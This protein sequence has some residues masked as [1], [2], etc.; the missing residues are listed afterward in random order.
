[1]KTGEVIGLVGVIVAAIAAGAAIAVILPTR[2][3]SRPA[4]VAEERDRFKSR[5]R[6]LRDSQ[7]MLGDEVLE[8]SPREWRAFDTIPVLAKASWILDGPQDVGTIDINLRPD[9]D[10]PSISRLRD[11]SRVLRGMSLAG[12][13]TYSEAIRDVNP[14]TQ[15]FN[16]IIYRPVG[17]DTDGSAPLSMT[18]GVAGYFDY[19]DTSEV[20]AYEA[21]LHP[22]NL[23][24]RRRITDPFDLTNRVASLGV[25]TLTIQRSLSGATFIMHKRSGNF[26]V[27][28]ALYHVVPAG[29]FTPSDVGQA[30][31]RVDFELWRNIVREYAEEL[32]DIPDAQGTGGRRLDYEHASP[33]QEMVQA[34]R[35]DRFRLYTFGLALDPLTF[36]PELLTVAVIDKTVFDKIFPPSLPTT[37]EGVVIEDIP[38]TEE[39]VRAYIDAPTTRHGAKACL[40]LAW[41][42]RAEL[43]L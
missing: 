25:L 42:Y 22:K 17:V 8:R 43:D 6:Q 11:A 32:L 3:S 30:A 31:V 38:F 12:N 37:E 7:V 33:Y 4:A 34:I 29:E 41:Q 13:M 5:L 40:T 28:D 27:G 23:G 19:L 1:M 39:N 16:G 2:R 35:D 24:V 21:T 10:D 15:Y 20:L 14:N 18:F 36:K 26:A 9:P